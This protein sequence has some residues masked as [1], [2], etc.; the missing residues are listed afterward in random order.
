[1]RFPLLIQELGSTHYPFYHWG[2]AL[3]ILLSESA[4]LSVWDFLSVLHTVVVIV[5]PM[6]TPLAFTALV[7]KGVI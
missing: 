6:S 5:M 2:S 4:P 7:V 1:M 3:R